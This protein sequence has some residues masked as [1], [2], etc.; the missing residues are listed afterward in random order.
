MQFVW[1]N[2]CPRARF[3][4]H[5]RLLVI[6]GGWYRRDCREILKE[7]DPQDPVAM[8]NNVTLSWDSCKV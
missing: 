1:N 6:L 2:W 5:S 8:G 3:F 4:F 7:A